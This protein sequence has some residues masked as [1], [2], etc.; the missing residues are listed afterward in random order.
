MP[1][2]FDKSRFENLCDESCFVIM[3]FLKKNLTVEAERLIEWIDKYDKSK[4]VVAHSKTNDFPYHPIVWIKLNGSK[5]FKDIVNTLQQ[6][7]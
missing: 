1:V 4:K 3:G 5:P 7:I 6:V 2:I